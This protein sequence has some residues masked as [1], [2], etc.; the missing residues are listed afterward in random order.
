[1]ANGVNKVILIGHLGK[2]PE[3]RNLDNGNKVASFTLATSESYTDKQGQKQTQTEWHNIVCWKGLAG[4]TEQYLKKGSKV[5]IEGKLTTRS[6][7]KDN[8]TRYITEIVAREMTML[9]SKP[10]V[11]QVPNAQTTTQ[12]P[13]AETV[14]QD[15]GGELPF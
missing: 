6:Y 9:D 13:P 8:Q 1:M 7:E 11:D 14:S 5:Y 4:V 10:T 2:D 3:V 12:Q 15:T